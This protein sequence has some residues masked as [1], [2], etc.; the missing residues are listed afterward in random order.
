MI[1]CEPA[2]RHSVCK[3]VDVWGFVSVQTFFH[4]TQFC[5]V[6]DCVCR[7]VAFH[8]SALTQTLTNRQ[9][10]WRH[11]VCR[12]SPGHFARDMYQSHPL[13]STFTV[14]IF[15][16]IGLHPKNQTFNE[17]LRCQFRTHSFRAS[18]HNITHVWS[19]HMFA[20]FQRSNSAKNCSNCQAHTQNRFTIGTI[21][22]NY[23]QDTH[24]EPHQS[25]SVNRSS[26][27]RGNAAWLGVCWKSVYM[28]S[29][30]SEKHMCN[31][32]QQRMYGWWIVQ[33]CS[34]WNLLR[35]RVQVHT[36]ELHITHTG[37]KKFFTNPTGRQSGGR[38][39]LQNFADVLW[40]WVAHHTFV[41][42]SMTLFRLAFKASFM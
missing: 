38:R 22:P 3:Q 24:T 37:A 26:M 18:N 4:N 9:V 39:W 40:S 13:K 20:C 6:R 21:Y 7:T 11:V 12:F 25:Q 29:D 36:I 8:C 30:G 5:A 2:Q 28:Q 15:V 31:A 17:S 41:M 16:M 14:G 35:K 1:A 33:G 10:G 19:T 27:H 34:G 42:L 23:A 32:D